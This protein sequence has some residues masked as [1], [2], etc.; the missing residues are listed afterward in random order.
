MDTIKHATPSYISCM[1]ASGNG[2]NII[3]FLN[4]QKYNNFIK[5]AVLSSLSL[6]KGKKIEK[7]KLTLLSHE[8]VNFKIMLSLQAQL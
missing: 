8:K 1:Y 7:R 6:T 2:Q 3:Y 5:R 4:I